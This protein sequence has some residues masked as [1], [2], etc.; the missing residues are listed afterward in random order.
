MMASGHFRTAVSLEIP[1]RS[2]T[3]IEVRDAEAD[4]FGWSFAR[5]QT[6]GDREKASLSRLSPRNTDIKLGHPFLLG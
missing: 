1:K 6:L 4:S 2:K 3:E 5:G